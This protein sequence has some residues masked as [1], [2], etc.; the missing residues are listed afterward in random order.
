MKKTIVIALTLFIVAIISVQTPFAHGSYIPSVAFSPDGKTLAAAVSN[1]IKLWNVEKRQIFG[2]LEGHTG[3][4]WSLSFSP[5]GK[6]IASGSVDN[7]VKLWDVGTQENIATFVGHEDE[8]TSV[9]FSPN[10]ALLASGA[11]DGIVKVWDV[12][13]Q[14]NIATMGGYDATIRA[15]WLGGWLTPVTFSQDGMLLAYGAADSSK[16]INTIQFWNVATQEN[17]ATIEAHTNG[18][19]SIDFSP[20][21]KKIVSRTPG[22]IK[23]WDVA[24]LENIATLFEEDVDNLAPA[25]FSPNGMLVASSILE[26][27]DEDE[28]VI[29]VVLWD[30]ETGEQIAS[31]LGHTD[32]IWSLSFSIDGTLLASAA[33]DGTVKLWDVSS[34]TKSIISA[35]RLTEDVNS[36]GLVNI[37]DLVLVASNLGKTGQDAADVNGDGTVNI[38]DLVLVAQ[39]LGKSI[40]PTVPAIIPQYTIAPEITEVDEPIVDQP[41]LP[42]AAFVRAN[43]PSGS[44]IADNASITLTFSEPPADVTVSSGTVNGVG[45]TATVS[46][47]FTPGPLELIVTWTDGAVTLLYNV[48]PPDVDPPTVTGGT[49]KDGDRDVDTQGINNDGRIEI[50]FSE[51]IS[52]NIA[53]QTEDGDDVGWLGKVEGNKATL[54]IIKGGELY[55]GTTYVVRGKVSDAAGNSIEFHVTFVTDGIFFTPHENLIDHWPFDEG[56]GNISKNFIIGSRDGEIF[57]AK[58]A[59]GKFGGAIEFDGVDG[60]IVVE[61]YPTF[62]ITENITFMAFLS[63]TDTLTN[64]AFIVKHD[65]FYVSL[66]EQNQLKFVLQPHDISVESTDNIRRNWYHFAVTFDGKTM[67]IYIDGQ[68]NSELSND[69]PIAPSEADLVMGQGFSGTIDEVRIYN[70]ALSQDEILNTFMGKGVL[71]P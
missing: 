35:E 25:V 45:K 13:T 37:Q 44:T 69:I 16:Q 9:S 68:L 53:L 14:E 54:E 19:I 55:S 17:I 64:R 6:N 36:D 8:V 4:I 56:A 41:I 22:E 40:D 42:A 32:V 62:D 5:D 39:H 31:V 10:G 24:T 21:G 61:D 43:P 51:D 23:L 1:E 66:G 59:K 47:P 46:G 27:T 34:F 20:D 57:G 70:K 11:W 63:P 49:V 29:R 2:M 7:T 71:P 65:S 15:G 52:G 67:R 12:N 60:Y 50:T 28:G 30:V 26:G 18:I 48:V 58:W 3:G 38:L 33:V